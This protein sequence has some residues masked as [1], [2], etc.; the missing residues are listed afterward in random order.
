[1]LQINGQM[2][3]QVTSR[4]VF[5]PVIVYHRKHPKKQTATKSRSFEY[6][7]DESVLFI[8]EK[9]YNKLILISIVNFEGS[10]HLQSEGNHYAN[11]VM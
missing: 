1:M 5:S 10:L 8:K 9:N 6:I 4:S 7:T 11:T 2:K 3:R